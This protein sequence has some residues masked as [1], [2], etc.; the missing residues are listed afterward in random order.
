MLKSGMGAPHEPPKTAQWL[1]IVND[2]H[3]T[4]HDRPGPRQPKSGEREAKRRHKTP[5]E[6]AAI[7]AAAAATASSQKQPATASNTQ[8]LPKAAS[9]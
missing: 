2:R 4:A 6:A 9:S 5:Q 7:S 8:H 3:K 1:K